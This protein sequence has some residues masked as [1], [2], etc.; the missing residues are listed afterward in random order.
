ML[1]MSASFSYPRQSSLV[2]RQKKLVQDYD[3][4]ISV[5]GPLK[6]IAALGLEELKI[7]ASESVGG[8]P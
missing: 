3:D 8:W 5:P 1:L 6:D 7:A 4:I 2:Q